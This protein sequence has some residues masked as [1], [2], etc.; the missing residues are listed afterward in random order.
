M[1]EMKSDV[2]PLKW[3]M[4]WTL[5]KSEGKPTSL[6]ARY[7]VQFFKS[8]RSWEPITGNYGIHLHCTLKCSTKNRTPIPVISLPILV[9]VKIV[10]VMQHCWEWALLQDLVTGLHST[11]F[12][13]LL[14]SS[15]L[16]GPFVFIN[17]SKKLDLHRTHLGHPAGSLHSPIFLY[18][19]FC[20]LY[21]P[22]YRQMLQ[23]SLVHQILCPNT[24]L[25][26]SSLAIY[27]LKTESFVPYTALARTP[28][29]DSA[30]VSARALS[31]HQSMTWFPKKSPA[32]F[33]LKSPS[34]HLAAF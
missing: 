7:K 33:K 9:N 29:T 8:R 25:L 23:V 30:E 15:S 17:Q 24:L 1:S 5:Y 18:P 34:V 12:T 10:L 27:V 11:I 6:P 32:H 13:G 21:F 19:G 22:S 16:H 3:V 4:M 2:L 20:D 31:W 26:Q 14:P 28:G